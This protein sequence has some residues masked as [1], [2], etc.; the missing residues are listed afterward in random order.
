MENQDKLFDTGPVPEEPEFSPEP[1][2]AAPIDAAPEPEDTVPVDA[3]PEPEDAVSPAAAEEAESGEVPASLTDLEAFFDAP[4][5][6]EAPGLQEAPE[7]EAVPEA[8]GN[9]EA[10]EAPQAGDDWLSSILPAPEMGEEIGPDENAIAMAGLTHPD[11]AE[12]ERIIEETKAAMPLD[13]AGDEEP[14]APDREA[15]PS[16]QDEALRNAFLSGEDL[17]TAFDGAPE[18]PP[19]PEDGFPPMDD[20]PQPD[21]EEDWEASDAEPEEAPE[22]PKPMRK[23]RP[24]HKKGYGLLGIPHIIA[25]FIW[26]AIA[27]AIGVSLGRILWLCVSDVL[28]FGREDKAVTI[29]IEDAGNIDAVAATLKQA[30]LIRYPELFKLYAGLVIDDGEL[31]EGTFTVNTLYDYHAL[32][33]A[34]SPNAAGRQTVRLTFPEGYTCKDIFAL[35]EKNEVCTVAELEEYAASGTLSDYWFLDGVERGEKYCLEGYLFPDTY[36]FYTKDEP[37][38]VLEK[39]LDAFDARFT[40]LMQESLVEFNGRFGDMLR[41]NGYEEDYV[42]S[43]QITIR[44]LTIVASL[45]EKEAANVTYE[46]GILNEENTDVNYEQGIPD[47]EVIASVIYNRLA[48]QRDYPYLNIDATVYYALGGKDGELTSSDLT[49]DS[50]FN[51]Y[52]VRGLPAG[53]ICNP[54]RTSFYA[55]LNPMESQYY[56]YIWDNADNQHHFFTTAEEHTAYAESMGSE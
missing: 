2:T 35:L 11:D 56:Y 20:Y 7:D 47:G 25:T 44:E 41:A 51:T 14:E 29:T 15:P 39:F 54:G 9:A 18:E 42:A 21:D 45:I 23:R 36:E 52:V 3:A 53:P 50:P 30:G 38:R 33:R 26:M 24:F 48:N 28:A 31:S 46:Q 43:H 1:E 49:V 32:T 13:H 10:P 37:R 19:F 16:Q 4:E 8:A 22:R 6:E 40:D 17:D 34:M 5:G 55:A 12:M 27:V